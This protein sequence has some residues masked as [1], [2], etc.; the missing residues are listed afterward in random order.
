VLKPG[1]AFERFNDV[2][3]RILRMLA[4]VSNI[5]REVATAMIKASGYLRCILLHISSFE[6][7]RVRGPIKRS[8]RSPQRRTSHR[9]HRTKA[10]L[11]SDMRLWLSHGS[12]CLVITTHCLKHSSVTTSHAVSWSLVS[13][14]VGR[15]DRCGIQFWVNRQAISWLCRATVLSRLRM[16]SIRAYLTL[17]AILGGLT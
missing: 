4:A 14:A 16:L 6:I 11:C 15:F 10:C 8:K 7:S 5:S 12:L 17:D 3:T 2:D 13:Q 1:K 9:L